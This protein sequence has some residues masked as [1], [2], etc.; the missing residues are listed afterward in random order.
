MDSV[1]KLGPSN[2]EAQ[3]D[4][5]QREEGLLK[6]GLCAVVYGNLGAHRLGSAFSAEN[7]NI[8]RCGS[9]GRGLDGTGPGTPKE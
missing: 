9:D 7:E 5:G 4:G 6:S 3:R 8:E 1:W 2:P